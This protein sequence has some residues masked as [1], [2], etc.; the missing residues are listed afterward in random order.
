MLLHSGLLSQKVHLSVKNKPLE[1]VLRDM[2]KQTGYSIIW[3]ETAFSQ[4]TAF[5]GSVHALPLDD[6]LKQ[7]LM[8]LGL[9]A[10]INGK[11]VVVRKAES[12][13]PGNAAT[14]PVQEPVFHVA[15]QVRD[16][17]GMP[18]ASASVYIGGTGI[19]T[20]SD[21]RGGF[22]LRGRWPGRQAAIT[23]SCQ[24]YV[25]KS[26]QVASNS[27]AEVILQQDTLRLNAVFVETGL[28]TR[29]RESYTGAAL[30]I[31]ADQLA[32]AGN[33]NLLTAL[34]NTNA[35]VH[36]LE[37]NSRGADPNWLPELQL[38]GNAS[39]PSI[40]QLQGEKDAEVNTPL[41]I[42]DGAESSVQRI[43]DM[44]TEEIESVTILKDAAAC[45]IYGSQAANGVIVFTTRSL[46]AGKGGRP[47]VEGKLSTSIQAA[48]FSSYRLM[49]AGEKL[50][51][52]NQ[53]GVYNAPAPLENL[54]RQ[55]YYGFLRDQ[56]RRGVETD[57][58][59]VPTRQPLSGRYHLAV[60]GEGKKFRYRLALRSN[61]NQGVMKQSFRKTLNL[62]FKTGYRYKRFEFLN[63]LS[64][65]ETR[66]QQSLYGSLSSYAMMNPYWLPADTS[67]QPVTRL[68]SE[69]DS[70]YFVQ[71]PN[72]VYDAITYAADQGKLN[73][74][75]N[76]FLLSYKLSAFL[77]YKLRFS[78]TKMYT[79]HS[80]IFAGDDYYKA[81]RTG[82]HYFN[83]ENGSG[84]SAHYDGFTS[85]EYSK[86]NRI[87][88]VF[89]ALSLSLKHSG[90]R[91][92]YFTNKIPDDIQRDS[93]TRMVNL[94]QKNAGAVTEAV[95]RSV[96]LVAVVNY[97]YKGQY[98]IDLSG[99]IDGSSQ[100]GTRGHFAP[101]WSVGLG[102]NVHS[103]ALLRRSAAVDKLTVR[104]SAGTAGSYRF[105]PYQ[106]LIIYQPYTNNSYYQWSGSRLTAIGNDRLTWQQQRKYNA[107]IDMEL[108]NGGVKATADFYLE[109]T[110]R[111]VSAIGLPLSN[112]FPFYMGNA[113]SIRNVGMEYSAVIRVARNHQQ[114]VSW[115]VSASLASNRNKILQLSQAMEDAQ[116]VQSLT[117]GV[118][119][120]RLYRAGYPVNTLWAVRSLGIDP[121]T[122][123]EVY[124][125]LQGNSTTTWNGAY[126][127]PFGQDEPRWRS[128]IGSV[129]TCK[130]LSVALLLRCRLGGQLYNQTLQQVDDNMIAYN[131]DRRVLEGRWL[132]PGDQAVFKSRQVTTPSY[133]SSRFVY[134]ETTVE[135]ANF[136]ANFCLP[137]ALVRRLNMSACSLAVN[138][139]NLFYLS[140]VHRERGLDFPYS[141]QYSITLQATF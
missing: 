139:D 7:V 132:K 116:K 129:L 33:R 97:D 82:I 45:A 106:S 31:G 40:L 43:I 93:V 126:L 104:I 54:K 48:D 86:R 137:A 4:Q 117:A 107:G 9:T 30:R 138:V 101:F 37:N 70:R 71:P 122:G 49:K 17:A 74:A 76:N 96:G 34:Q 35:A 32:V 98:F 60:T 1:A 23:V 75:T 27:H 78:F 95:L 68:G 28:F 125:D 135:G 18:V 13:L 80:G 131:A 94:F 8:P 115:Q 92:N 83:Y 141:T 100:F 113:G 46:K 21:E 15:G 36:V 5:S 67:G 39:I 111:L 59:S 136:Y 134:N 65:Y 19:G 120:Q 88:S 41:I 25:T 114:T 72:P 29:R 14:A 112:G 130:S 10:H 42:V 110:H 47:R 123:K 140:S 38:R 63:Y 62:D 79:D 102:W 91:T 89:S 56:Q 61:D 128:T 108:W 24:G 87:H 81:S 133:V 103:S 58:L 84:R 127:Q 77:Q 2:E 44:N 119:P 3:N 109:T 52:E 121:A 64:L 11:I 50:E 105:Q 69:S 85:L 57:W 99:R 26:L 16:A 124:T 118:E 55:E 73:L 53:L 51:L 12:L 20:L 6:A 22:L 66:S 90:E